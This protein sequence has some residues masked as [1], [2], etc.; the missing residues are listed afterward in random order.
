[1]R[2]ALGLWTALV[3][4]ALYAPVAV[5]A[6]Y[7]FNAS[8]S[9]T[10]AGFTTDWYGRLLGSREIR[11]ALLNTLLLSSVSTLLS[12]VLG[13]LAALAARDRFRG[14]RLYV[15]LV[16]LPVAVP[17]IVLAFAAYSLFRASGVPLSVFTAA[18]A[19]ATF[20]LSYVGINNR[21]GGIEPTPLGI[22]Y[23]REHWFVK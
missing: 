11:D 3:L 23:N 19:H 1:M 16:S 10:W 20:N 7:S 8:T 13:T 2:T 9:S 5:M 14:K 4:A 17:D 22:G 6:A 15:A 18:L 12:T 21:I